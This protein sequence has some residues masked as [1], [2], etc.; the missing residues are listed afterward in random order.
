VLL[1]LMG[2]I[3]KYTVEMGSGAMTYVPSFTK[4]GSAI[5]RLM[6]EMHRQNRDPISLL[7]FFQNKEIRL[8]MRGGG[9]SFGSKLSTQH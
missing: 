3:M 6:R 2:G 9:V 7:L 5:R 1:L 8:K 4:T